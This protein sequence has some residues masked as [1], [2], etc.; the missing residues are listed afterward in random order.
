VKIAN[1]IACSALLGVAIAC[2]GGGGSGGGAGSMT[3][4]GQHGSG[5]GGEHGNGGSGASGGGSG[6]GSG[7][8]V[9]SGTGSGGHDGS[10]GGAGGSGSASD[11]GEMPCTAKCSAGEH[12][13]LVRVMCIRAPCPPQP[14]CVDDAPSGKGCGSRGQAPCA[15]G[16]FCN[17]PRS[18]QCGAADAP[19]MCATQTQICPDIYQPVCGCDGQTYASECTANAAGVS[20]ASDGPCESTDASTPGAIDCDPRKILCK[21]IAPE[22][23]EGQ[24]PSVSGSCYGDCVPL[25]SCPCSGP[26][27]CPNPDTGTCHM[28]AGHC[29]PY[30]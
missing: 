10:S 15:A 12:C 23:P 24:V 28:S 16:E 27:Q 3:D 11:A 17:F 26:E 21:R 8:H 2:G 25:E 20:A 19:G 13:E 18:A 9:S 7:G 6:S 22:C 30:V 29:G 1:W 14:T 5:S 4:A